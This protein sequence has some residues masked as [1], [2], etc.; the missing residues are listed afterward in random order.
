MTLSATVVKRGPM[1]TLKFDDVVDVNLK[2]VMRVLQPVPELVAMA[3]AA[4][5]R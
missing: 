4:P 2:G 3:P 1:S 5:V